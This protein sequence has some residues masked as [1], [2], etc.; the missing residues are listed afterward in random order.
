MDHKLYQL[1]A[2]AFSNTSFDP[3]K[4]AE[5]TCIEFDKDIEQLMSLGIPEE[6]IT[7]YESLFVKWIQSESR[8][9]SWAIT[10]PA[11]FPVARNEKYRV[12]ANNASNQVCEYFDNLVAA[13]KKE[14]FYEEHPEARPIM[15]DDDNAVERIQQKIDALKKSHETMKKVNAILRKMPVDQAALIQLLGSEEAANNVQKPDFTG[16]A[17]YAPFKLTNILAEIKRLEQRKKILTHTKE[18]GSKEHGING[19]R[20]VENTEAMR[21]QL[22][23]PAKPTP[24]IITLLKSHGFKWAPT[25]SAWQRQL[26]GNAI[27]DFNHYVLPAIKHINP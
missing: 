11:N 14:K 9:M 27:N 15:A 17:G 10:G 19:V 20:V 6:K 16:H 26:T 18:S 13:A 7:K 22:F 5:R 2:R 3:E 8:C 1:A 24:E 25:V 23:F 4:R 12:A 21:L